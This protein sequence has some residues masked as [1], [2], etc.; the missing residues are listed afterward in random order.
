M[1]ARVLYTESTI[2]KIAAG[3]AAAPAPERHVSKL[4][5][6]ARLTPDL[7][8]AQKRG[9]SLDDLVKLLADQGLKTHARA[10]ARVLRDHDATE[11]Q[12]RARKPRKQ[13]TKLGSD[14]AHH[15]PDLEDA[16]QQRLAA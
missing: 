3:I 4:D 6:L 8:E 2:S 7:K 9:H 5:A 16:G 14:D 13:S 11:G 1:N 10:I 12:K 15:R